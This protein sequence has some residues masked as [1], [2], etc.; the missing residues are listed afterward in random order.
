MPNV[1][2]CRPAVAGSGTGGG[3]CWTHCGRHEATPPRSSSRGRAGRV[4]ARPRPLPSGHAAPSPDHGRRPRPR[5]VLRAAAAAL[6]AQFLIGGVRERDAPRGKRGRL[7]QEADIEDFGGPEWLEPELVEVGGRQLWI[8]A[9][10]EEDAPPRERPAQGWLP[11]LELGLGVAVV[12]VVLAFVLIPD[13]GW[14]SLD[15]AEQA[16]TEERLAAEAARIA[17]H[18]AEIHCDAR[19]EAVGVV[20]HAD[21]IAEVGGRNAYLT[22]AICFR[23]HELAFEG[24]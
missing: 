16:R 5:V 2:R 21:G 20:Q 14:S 10:I 9:E 15:A 3:S 1:W 19:G 18:G 6:D 7:P 13:S 11:R 22:P 12:L 24:D 17:G 4:G 8:P 23:L